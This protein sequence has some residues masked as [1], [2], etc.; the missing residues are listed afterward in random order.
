MSDNTSSSHT[1]KNSDPISNLDNDGDSNDGAVVLDGNI[2]LSDGNEATWP[3]IGGEMDYQQI[4]DSRWRSD[5]A[6]R[7]VTETGAV[8]A[9]K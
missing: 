6:H 1:V 9:G 4:D 7:W 5:L 3:E 2:H 8:E